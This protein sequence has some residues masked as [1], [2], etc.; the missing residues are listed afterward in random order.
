MKDIIIVG[1]G[2]GNINTLTI[3]GKNHIDKAEVLIGAKRMVKAVN[4]GNKPFFYSF[5]GNEIKNFIQSSNYQNYVV[6]MSGDTGFYSGTAPLLPILKEYEVKVI[7][8][9][10]TVSYFCSKIKLSWEDACLLSLHGRE[11]NIVLAVR[12][13]IKTFALTDGRIGVMCRKLTQAGL[14]FVQIYVGENL[15]YENE[16]I[17]KGTAEEFQN[18]DFAPLSAVFIV[19]PDYKTQYHI[20]IPDDE[21][22]R[23]TV[24]MTKSEIRAII[25]SKLKLKEDSI[26]YDIGAGTGSV[27]IE[28]AFLAKKGLV[29]AIEQKEEAI[30]LIKKNQDKFQIDNL[31]V[32]SGTAP[33]VMEILEKPDMAFIGGSKGNMED[34]IQS[35][36][37]KNPGIRLVISSIALETLTEALRLMK[38]F[39][40]EEVDV[41]QASIS[42]TKEAGSYHMLMGQNPVFIISGR[43]K[44]S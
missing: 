11:E 42:K 15:S 31:R 43:G 30:Q 19:N 39:E 4:T 32:I 9:I 14:G 34:I 24:P 12:Q 7:P 6:L 21:F 28:M 41:V 35:L 8:G 27:S 20:G 18:A 33:E 10:T 23:G 44:T 13:H 16:R 5:D 2:M 40:F 1:V 29:Y 3:E 25:L 37:N 36:L 22:I 38:E 17:I 26:L